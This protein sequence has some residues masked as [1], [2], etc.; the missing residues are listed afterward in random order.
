MIRFTRTSHGPSLI[1]IDVTCFSVLHSV[2]PSGFILLGVNG[3]ARPRC[4]LLC[5]CA[6]WRYGCG[7]GRSFSVGVE[8]APP[9]CASRSAAC[10]AAI[11]HTHHA[12]HI[13]DTDKHAA[14]G[15]VIAVIGES[16]KHGRRDHDADSHERPPCTRA[17]ESHRIG[18]SG[19]QRHRHAHRT[20]CHTHR[21]SHASSSSQ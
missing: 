21:R 20:E 10:H 9:L 18:R 3:V 1:P 12:G 15:S 6:E 11:D 17:V 13:H 19:Q 4:R 16:H 5:R 7:C 2:L 8:C 14:I